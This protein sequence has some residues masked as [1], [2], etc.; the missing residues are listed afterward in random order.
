MRILVTG[1]AG[2]IGSHSAELLEKKGNE[3]I[4]FD[5]FSTGRS[6]NL[7]KFRGQI[8]PGDITDQ[9]AL[10]KVFYDFQPHAILHLAA[11]SAISTSYEDP[12]KDMRV[13]AAGTANLISLALKYKVK[14][15]VFSSTSAVYQEDYPFWET[16]AS[17][18]LPCIPSNPYGISKLA[19]E[20]LIRLLFPEHLILRYG[21]VYGPRQKAIGG[22]Q[23]IARAFAHFIQGTD[24]KVVGH[25]N[26][27]RDF[28]FVE[29]IALCN[30]LALTSNVTGTFNAASGK[31]VSVNNVLSEIE[32][33]HDVTGYKWEHT[34][35]NDP[36][37]DVAL[38][39]SKIY[40]ELGWKAYTSIR[41]GIKKTSDWWK[42]NK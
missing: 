32:K 14:R 42:E 27:K 9:R 22:N 24:F 30:Y 29:D 36:R 5:N 13:N 20:Q 31:S 21:N 28:V 7:K 26:Q 12:A 8:S 10:E 25:G 16:G 4:V 15:F 37:G 40:S 33:I 34:H 17:E 18:K 1:A 39:V 19:A 6:E 11:Q 3:V 35:Q 23:V 2:F 38:K 41:D